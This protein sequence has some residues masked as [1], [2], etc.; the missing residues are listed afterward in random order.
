MVLDGSMIVA[1]LVLLVV[2]WAVFFWL[3]VP[4]PVRSILAIVVAVA[5][6][7]WALV[8]MGLVRF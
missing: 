1:L 7:L 2:G 3:P 4:Q 8:L 6:V 5:L